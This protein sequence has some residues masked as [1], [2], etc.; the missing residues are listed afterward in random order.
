MAAF[1]NHSTSVDALDQGGEGV[2]G[3]EKVMFGTPGAR[4]PYR[5][6]ACRCWCDDE[7]GDLD[8]LCDTGLVHHDAVQ[9]IVMHIVTYAG[10]D[11]A[12]SMSPVNDSSA[13][14]HCQ[15]L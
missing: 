3:L 9:R 12:R 2:R 1:I 14:F 5:Q 6:H 8:K 15:C 13:K 7:T 10:I 4:Q 11:R